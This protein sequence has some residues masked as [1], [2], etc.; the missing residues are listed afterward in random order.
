N[1]PHDA[2]RA[3]T[4]ST[5][6]RTFSNNTTHG[7][8]VSVATQPISQLNTV[9]KKRVGKPHKVSPSAHGFNRLYFN[10]STDHH[11]RFAGNNPRTVL[12]ENDSL[13]YR[14]EQCEGHC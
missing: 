11:V 2:P 12:I 13:R 3:D 9:N 8:S 10:I 4:A 6:V 5:P 7:A 14:H 1:A